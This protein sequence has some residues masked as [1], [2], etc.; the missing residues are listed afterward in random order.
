[1]RRISILA[2]AWLSLSASAFAAECEDQSQTGLNR[3]ADAAYQKADAALN[4]VYKDITRR[5]KSDTAAMQLLVTAQK[6]WLGF[7]DAECA[8]VNSANAGGSI[9]PMV[10]AQCL[11]RL[12]KARTGDL[13]AYLK[14]GEGDLGCP[15]PNE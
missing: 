10:Y 11:E 9:Y 3:C 13:R 12:T 6:A 7:R 4:G 2:C 8:F 14:C 15:V 5:L 1:M